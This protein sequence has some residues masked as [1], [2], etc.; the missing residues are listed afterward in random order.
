MTRHADAN[1]EMLH[2]VATH[3]GDLIDDVV[4]TG[5]CV[6]SLLITDEGA[7][8]V[9]PTKD[10]DVIIEVLSRRQYYEFEDRLRKIGFVQDA[11][12]DNLF[13]GW[14]IEGVKV[15]ILP[16]SREITGVGN[17]WFEVAWDRATKIGLDDHLTV[18]IVSAPCF[19]ATKLVA[20]FDRGAEDYLASHDL[21]DI[22]AVIDGRESLTA[23][24][25]A[26][27]PE[28]RQYISESFSSFLADERFRD[29]LPGHL[30]SDEASQARLPGLVEKLEELAA[31]T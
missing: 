21:E 12:D 30:P 23:E 15:D 8:D 25:R 4:F 10:V 19:V 13:C 31:G 5:G 16:T 22:V 26:E 2:H 1:L 29:S 27:S 24:I 3:L 11:R 28:L 18:R 17:P 7:P 9:R 14:E 20:F 6:V